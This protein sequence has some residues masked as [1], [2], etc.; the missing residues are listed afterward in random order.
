MVEPMDAISAWEI[1]MLPFPE[2]SSPPVDAEEAL[3]IC[4]AVSRERVN[5]LDIAPADSEI[6]DMGVAA[7]HGKLE[8]IPEGVSG[9][10]VGCDREDAKL[11]PLVEDADDDDAAAARFRASEIMPSD[12]RGT[13]RTA[14]SVEG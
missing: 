3:G 13:T 2:S 6:N 5:E 7:I 1:P 12:E 4:S 11:G 8:A 10:H 14:K 9:V